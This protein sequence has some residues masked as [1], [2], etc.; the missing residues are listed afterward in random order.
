[1]LELL[2]HTSKRAIP[3]LAF[4]AGAIILTAC[5]ITDLSGEVPAYI[6]I[7]QFEVFTEPP[8]GSSSANITEAWL[9]VDGNFLGAYSLPAIVPVLERGEK[10]IS[11]QAGIKD[12]GIGITREIYP[13]YT[14]FQTSIDLMPERTD[15]LRP[16]IGYRQRTKFAFVEN[17]EDSGHLFRELRAGDPF[18]RVQ[19]SGRQAFEGSSSAL[20]QLDAERPFVE[21]ATLRSFRSLTADGVFVYL[22][23]NYRS[24][25]PVVFG[26]I[27]I[28]PARPGS[29]TPLF[30]PGFNP[31]E[32]WNKIYFNLSPLFQQLNFD[33]YKIALQAFIPLEDGALVRQEAE[34]RL[35][36]I[37]LVHF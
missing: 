23:V 8:E 13:F 3:L 14:A 2:S 15:T 25:V 17:F 30:D 21:I 4:F 37:K 9:T 28:D 10:E 34:I 32:E 33:E 36:N 26:I 35:D 31:S 19:L 20:I 11:L 27:G 29:E 5:D 6:Y 24:D 12:N 22:E 7:D 16:T 18:N 1:M